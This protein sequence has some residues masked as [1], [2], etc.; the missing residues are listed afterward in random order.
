MRG[1]FVPG[2]RK[3]DTDNS[4]TWLQESFM[5]FVGMRSIKTRRLGIG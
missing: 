3:S 4:I 2:P 1:F 5:S